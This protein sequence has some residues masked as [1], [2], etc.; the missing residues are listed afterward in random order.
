M[1]I[2]YYAHSYR[3][4]DADVVG[5][6]AT[7]MRTLDMTP[8]LDPP[9]DTLNAAKP[10]RHLRETDG[11]VAVLTAREGGP[12][13]YILFEI[14]L[15]L[16]ARVPI[17]VFVEDVIPDGIVPSRVLQRRFNRGRL[18]REIRDHRHVLR[19]LGTYMG[20]DPPPRYQP[21][22]GR[23]K[24]LLVGLD[25][26]SPDAADQASHVVQELDFEPVL[27][28]GDPD[29]PLLDSPDEE[30]LASVALAVGH[31][32]TQN[33]RDHSAIGALQATLTPSILLAGGGWPS[34][35]GTP[36]E[37]LPR[38]VDSS[39]EQQLTETVRTEISIAWQDYVELDNQAEVARYTEILL[40][41]G[42]GQRK[43]G[44]DFRQI[45]IEELIM[46]DKYEAKNVGAMG[47]GA[48]VD[49]V[50]FYELWGEHKNDLDLGA[51][52]QD[53]D[54]LREAMKNEATD[55]N[56][57]LAIAEI[58]QARSAAEEGDGPTALQRLASAGKWAF[59]VATKIGTTVA[60][61]AL[62]TSL[63]I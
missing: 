38:V 9:S 63:G 31:V 6:F 18:V 12:S 59:E 42:A 36:N 17:L 5:F 8:S 7:L 30:S 55:P 44:S 56:H 48:S 24:C 25:A 16:R 4:E 19:I 62:K 28:A 29:S 27:L 34:Q 58:V 2:V 46:R 37:Y 15:S 11:L 51:L 22:T 43:Y 49:K 1:N 60:A 50:T 32:Q 61:A 26:H 47:P 57:D 21:T 53:L 3:D 33:A 10:A 45:V 13:P 54:T 23:R 40:H 52:V 14:A 41:E 35:P 20:A 39:N